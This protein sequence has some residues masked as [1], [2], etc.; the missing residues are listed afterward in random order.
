MEKTMTNEHKDELEIAET[1]G[2][3][4]SFKRTLKVRRWL[5]VT[6]GLL[7]TI[8]LMA[9]ARSDESAV[10][11]Y[12]TQPI[13]RGGLKVTVTATG[14]LEPINQVDVGSELSGIIRTVGVSYND[15][16]REGQVLATLDTD[17]LKAQVLESTAA[18]RSARAKVEDAEATV[19]EQKLALERTRELTGEELLSR[20]E[21]D[22]A[23]AVFKRAQA[24]LASAKAQVAQAEAS[25]NARQTDLEKTIV[26]S[27]INGVVLDRNVEPGQTVAAS[28]QAPVLFT[29]AEDLTQMELH[30]AV[31]EADIGM[32]EEGQAAT[33]TV[34]AYPGR[35]FPAEITELRYAS[36][37][38]N[39]VVTYQAVLR[40]ENSDLALRPGMTATAEIEVET[41]ENAILVPN[42]A[43][44]FEPPVSKEGSIQ[45]SGGLLGAILP[46][47]PGGGQ[48]SRPE[49]QV[50]GGQK[51]WML[52][53]E[54]PFALSIE[55]GATDGLKTEIIG[56][57]V[58]PGLA[59]LVDVQTGGRS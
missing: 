26:R 30:V 46:R 19:A 2:V 12:E 50:V 35:S 28:L 18:L 7:A 53:D 10:T 24:D 13:E 36:E 40:V 31:D 4:D 51:V 42:A 39:G 8:G 47:R 34:D 56:G 5:A 20:S 41:V 9:W 58:E 33:F 16:V 55:T 32:V 29:L 43:L 57:D 3:Q 14:N 17:R 22:T 25:L 27:P 23:E 6:A 44:R 37:T 59:L 15:A 11:R 52:K 48:R 54:Q 21:L 38:V 45:S 1:L 49:T